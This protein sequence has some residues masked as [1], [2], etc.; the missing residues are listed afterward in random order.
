[1]QLLGWINTTG[2]RVQ[3]GVSAFNYGN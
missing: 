3:L 1:M 2:S